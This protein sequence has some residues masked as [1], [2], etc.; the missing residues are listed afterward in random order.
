MPFSNKK[1]PNFAIAT[2][3]SG[4]QF[5]PIPDTKGEK[6]EEK[7]KEKKE[8]TAYSIMETAF[9]ELIPLCLK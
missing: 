8:D 3:K 5:T 2:R 9:S 7:G 6:W 4:L 1:G